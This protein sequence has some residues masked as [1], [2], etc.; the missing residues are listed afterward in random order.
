MVCKGQVPG[1][2]TMRRCGSHPQLLCRCFLSGKVTE[3]LRPKRYA[4]VACL[5]NGLDI[6]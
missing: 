3:R 4:G 6:P 5:G 2:H 1:P